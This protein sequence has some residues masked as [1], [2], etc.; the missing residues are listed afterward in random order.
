VETTKGNGNM[1]SRHLVSDPDF[2]RLERLAQYERRVAIEVDRL[3][4]R[5][6]LEH[7]ATRR[8]M[9]AHGEFSL[10]KRQCEQSLGLSIQ[11]SVDD[12]IAARVS[13]QEIDRYFERWDSRQAQK[14]LK[15]LRAQRVACER[16]IGLHRRA[17]LTLS[18]YAKQCARQLPGLRAEEAAQAARLAQTQATV[19]VAR[20]VAPRPRGA[21][22]P[23]ARRS[24][25]S[26]D[27][28]DGKDGEPEPP[29][30]L[31]GRLC[32]C[33]CGRGLDGRR[34]D[35]LVCSP[36]CQKRVER[37]KQAA[38]SVAANDRS[39]DERWQR[40]LPLAADIAKVEAAIADGTVATA[41]GE[42]LLAI[43]LRRRLR[44]LGTRPCGCDHASPALDPDGDSVCALCGRLLD[45]V[46]SRING[47][48]AIQALMASNGTFVHKRARTFEWRGLAAS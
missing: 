4:V 13:L 28:E 17:G 45:R 48:D 14:R 18:G 29:G 10:E 16:D 35:A 42:C 39:S 5:R 25:R 20:L 9:R 30:K 37:D 32:A 40:T 43:L 26:G 12:E 36:R 6:D 44:M 47:F 3:G 33:G 8:F 38:A 19:R 7:P 24:S 23:R 22:R 2:A 11:V 21:G 34:R 15:A 27:G 1:S 41:T 31:A 46:A